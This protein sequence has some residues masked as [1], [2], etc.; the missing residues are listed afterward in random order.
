MY[1]RDFFS[2]IGEKRIVL[3]SVPATGLGRNFT[4]VVIRR[5]DE[6]NDLLH[7]GTSIRTQ[8]INRKICSAIRAVRVWAAAELRRRG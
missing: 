6:G 5:N 8:S 7:D 2:A 4:D 3:V 1:N